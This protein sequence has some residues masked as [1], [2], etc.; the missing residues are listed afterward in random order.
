MKNL[1]FLRIKIR[2]KGG[3]GKRTY[4]EEYSLGNLLLIILPILLRK[5]VKNIKEF[6]QNL[7]YEE[8]HSKKKSLEI[9]ERNTLE[10]PA[11]E[12]LKRRL[13]T[14]KCR[15]SPPMPEITVFRIGER[16]CYPYSTCEQEEN[17]EDTYYNLLTSLYSAGR[18]L[19]KFIID[20]SKNTSTISLEGSFTYSLLPYDNKI[21]WLGTLR[22]N[23]FFLLKSKN[24]P[25]ERFTPP[26]ERAWVQYHYEEVKILIDQ[27]ADLLL[28]GEKKKNVY[29]PVAEWLRLGWA[30]MRRIN[31]RKG[32]SAIYLL[33]TPNSRLSPFIT[34][35]TS[36]GT[37]TNSI[38]AHIYPTWFAHD[39][40]KLV[41][42]AE[43]IRNTFQK[44]RISSFGG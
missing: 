5:I 1:V 2:E 14:I 22:N 27:Q 39:E 30:S 33:K 4:L 3:K 9:F 13:R 28:A 17:L 40:L 15:F 10:T 38:R 6:G 41:R 18:T 24:F 29:F 8:K 31:K 11:V 26:E 34:V 35:R 23:W 20:E 12:D 7:F 36:S 21:L 44:S 19:T 25:T 32:S 37:R 43:K 16:R 42:T